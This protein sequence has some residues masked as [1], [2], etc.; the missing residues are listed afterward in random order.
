MG[1]QSILRGVAPPFVLSALRRLR[2]SPPLGPP[3]F[4]HVPDAW[5]RLGTVESWDA[6]AIEQTYRDKWP[7]FA[8]L[9][10]GAGPLGVS[11]ESDFSTAEDL[12]AHN[13]T[14][15][16]AYV[17]A[18]AASD[19]RLSILDW[20]GG[21]GHYAL[22]TRSVLPDIEVA[23]T[24]KDVP[25]LAA[26]G[27][28]W[29]PGDRFISDDADLAGAYDLVMSSGAL[30]YAQ[31]WRE[32]VE[33]L[34]AITRRSLYLTRMPIAAGVPSFPYV[35]RVPAEYG[36]GDDTTFVGWCFGREEFLSAVAGTGLVLTREFVVG[37][38]WPIAGAPAPPRVGG[39]LFE[40]PA[41]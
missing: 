25:S 14:M 27:D 12:A 13:A 30:H 37:E 9:V 10:G 3:Q 1:F 41:P 33:R 26:L 15:T 34:A 11:H 2:P 40:R 24:S 23:Y 4:E 8:A 21:P 17:A 20:G 19:G 39:F 16:F 6:S 18:R 29:L 38:A 22:L 35:Q 5:E 28:E 36:Y 7:R 32:M 31:D